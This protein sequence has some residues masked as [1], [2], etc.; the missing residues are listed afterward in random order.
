MNIDVK[1]ASKRDTQKIGAVSIATG[2]I[3]QAIS[4]I[5]AGG[6]VIV[7]DD[8]SRENEGDLIASA[9]SITADMVAF[10]VNYSTGI[11]CASMDGHRADAMALPP[12]VGRNDD[13][14][15][16]AFTVTCD[17]RTAGTG[18][19]AIDRTLTFRVLAAEPIDPAALRR[20]GHIFPLRAREGGVLVREGHTEAAYD[21]ARLAGHVPI[22]VLCELVNVDGSMMRGAQID[23]FAARFGLVKVSVA[24]LINWRKAHGDL[25]GIEQRG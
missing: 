11:L 24:E 17:A 15:A 22:G 9:Q 18:V 21:L 20:P 16:T 1:T 3:D 10:M 2:Q 19:S 23:E 25:H 5:S 8:D 12:M 6:M 13:P 4:T 14:Q 7:V